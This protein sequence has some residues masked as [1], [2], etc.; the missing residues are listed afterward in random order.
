MNKALFLDRDGTLIEDIPYLHAVDK[1]KL[2]PGTVE[3]L[4]LAKKAKF[5]LFLFTNQSGIGRGYYSLEQAE[6]CNKAL[7][8]AIG[9]GPIFDA[10]CIAPERPDEAPIYRKPS[11]KFILEMINAYQ[12]SPQHSYMVGDRKSDAQAGLNAYIQAIRVE[13]G[14][15]ISPQEKEWIA[16]GKLKAFPDLL[17]FITEGLGLRGV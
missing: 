7:V 12:L 15:P 4:A 17:S 6:N 13:T 16:Q 3:A 10:I 5:H 9:L 8:E 11:P 2:L 14:E 1:I